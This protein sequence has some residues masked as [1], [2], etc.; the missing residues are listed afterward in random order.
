MVNIKYLNRWFGLCF[1]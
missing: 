1:F